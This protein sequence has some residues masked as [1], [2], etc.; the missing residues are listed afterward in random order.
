MRLNAPRQV[1]WI[2]A[3]ILGILGL[4]G[5]VVTIA[6]LTDLAF[7]LVL[8]GLALMLLATLLEGL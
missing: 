7:W 5:A 8:V 6:V 2:I 3:L 1:T 4:I